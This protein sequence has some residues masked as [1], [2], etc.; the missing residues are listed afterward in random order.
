MCLGENASQS[1][2][3]LC[4]LPWM[5]MWE[6]PGGCHAFSHYHIQC[7]GGKGLAIAKCFRLTTLNVGEKMLC[8]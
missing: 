7:K 5:F 1:P 6:M 2:N 8:G 3:I 4:S